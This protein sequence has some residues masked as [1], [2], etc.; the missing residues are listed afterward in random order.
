MKRTTLDHAAHPRLRGSPRAER[1][2][3]AFRDGV[4]LKRPRLSE[5]LREFASAARETAAAF[6]AE[7]EDLLAAAQEADRAALDLV[8]CDGASYGR[9]AAEFAAGLD[10][11][12]I[13]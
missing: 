13:E 12:A 1:A 3:A 6:P 7:A 10:K 9:L 11:A 2:R 8:D 4:R 5:H